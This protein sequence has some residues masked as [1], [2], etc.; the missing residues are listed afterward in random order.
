M[1]SVIEATTDAVRTRGRLRT[2]TGPATTSARHRR[3]TP[4]RRAGQAA[5]WA[6]FALVMVVLAA[7]V[8]L[9][10]VLGAVPLAVL[11]SSMEPTLPPGT[12]VVSQPVETAQLRAG[13]V[14]TFQPHSGDPMLITHRIIALGYRADGELTFT[15]RGDNNSQPDSPIVADQ[16]MGKVI[17]NVP[18]VGYV[19]RA[20]GGEQGWVVSVGGAL[21]IAYA[22]FTLVGALLEKRYRRSAER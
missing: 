3:R 13:D 12:L 15:T 8:V 6:V 11:T 17:Y 19:T 7:V 10:R 4:L 1:H 21:L 20:F 5:L 16:V 14:I 2:D 22:V 9:P 18:Y